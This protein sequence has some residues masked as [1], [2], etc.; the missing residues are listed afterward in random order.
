MEVER[1]KWRRDKYIGGKRERVRYRD[2]E[3]ARKR[4]IG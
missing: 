4:E 1:E 2:K 3:K